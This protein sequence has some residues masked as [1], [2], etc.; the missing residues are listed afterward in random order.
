MFTILTNE[1]VKNSKSIFAKIRFYI[2]KIIEPYP[3]NKFYA[4]ISYF[5]NI[6]TIIF[7]LFV[8]LPALWSTSGNNPF[9]D[10]LDA[11]AIA[12]YIVLT[13]DYILRWFISDY[14]LGKGYK[15]FFL[16]FVSF[17]GIID[18]LGIFPIWFG[19]NGFA[20]FLI[21]RLFKIIRFFPRINSAFILINKTLFRRWK[22]LTIVFINFIFMIFFGATLIW[23]FENETNPDINTFWNAVYMM[24]IT[25]TTIG[26]GDITPITTGGRIVVS[27]FSLVGISIIAIITAIVVTSFTDELEEVRRRINKQNKLSREKLWKKYR[28]LTKEEVIELLKKYKI[29]FPERQRHDQL[30]N[31]YITFLIKKENKKNKTDQVE[32]V[33]ANEL[34]DQEQTIEINKLDSNKDK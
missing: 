5:Y 10:W 29:S 21:F 11:N 3:E 19:A 31:I 6:L 28:S 4:Y 18:F 27:I 12:F 33:N 30:V 32:S 1:T 23:L 24:F 25:M 9:I 8:L 17:W 20:I 34:L 16:F 26:F 7:A 2:Y 13:I 15:S 22:V 14:T